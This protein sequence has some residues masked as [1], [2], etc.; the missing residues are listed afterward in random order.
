M[1]SNLTIPSIVAQSLLGHLTFD[2]A[3][4]ILS[5]HG[6]YSEH[7]KMV[8]YTHYIVARGDIDD[9]V[10]YLNRF[11]EEERRA[12]VDDS[13]Y[14]TYYGNTLHTCAYWNTG[15]KALTIYRYLHTAGARPLRDYYEQFPWEVEGVVYVC[16]IRGC[17]VADGADR[18]NDEFSETQAD[19]FRY[20]GD[21]E[22]AR[23]ITPIAPPPEPVVWSWGPSTVAM[24][25]AGVECPSVSCP[26]HRPG[27]PYS[28]NSDGVYGSHAPG[29]N[30]CPRGTADIA[31]GRM[32]DSIRRQTRLLLIHWT[33]RY[34]A[35]SAAEAAV[36]AQDL[37]AT[38]NELSRLT[39]VIVTPQDY[40][41]RVL[42]MHA[43][44]TA[45]D[46]AIKSDA[47]YERTDLIRARLDTFLSLGDR[48]V[49]G[50]VDGYLI[51]TEARIHIAP[52]T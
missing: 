1:S 51:A 27:S 48:R 49:L 10:D 11:N 28:R 43:A 21:A 14:D 12:I 6:H 22:P 36:M 41:R 50:N 18:N 3:D 20:F 19:I 29:C 35:T 8:L 2:Q 26:L 30:G 34:D 33:T 37:E 42:V 17:N 16:P 44:A 13:L 39:R 23:P 32:A 9:L 5:S 52:R 24:A 46:S 4:A 47:C 15:D 7:E 45:L 25:G 31:E 38:I 40:A